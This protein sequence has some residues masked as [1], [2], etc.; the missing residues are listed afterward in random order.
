MIAQ[1][2]KSSNTLSIDD[3]VS[4]ALDVAKNAGADAA[5]AIAVAGQSDQVQIRLGKTEE[6]ERTE[7]SGIGLR[8]FI[9]RSSSIVS[10]NNLTTSAIK[11]LAERAV[12][13]ATAASEDPHTGLAEPDLFAPTAPDLDLADARQLGNYELIDR[14]RAA[15]DAAREVKGITNSLGANANASRS[16]IFLL[17]SKGFNASYETTSFSISCS[18][19]AGSGTNM[20]RDYDYTL[21]RHFDDLKPAESIG[22]NA[23]ER[24]IRMVGAERMR[25]G[26]VTVVYEPRTAASLLGHFTAAIN[27]QSIARKAS[28]LQDRMGENIFSNA[29]T[30]IDDPLRSQGLNS[31]PFDGEGLAGESRALVQN[32]KLNSWLL[33]LSSAH[34]LGLHS[35]GHASRG[36]STPP[37]PSPTNLTLEPGSDSPETLISNVKHGLFITGL[38]GMGVNGVTGDYSRGADG[39]AIENG[40]LTNPVSEVTIAGTLPEMFARMH[41]GNDLEICTGR[42]T[43]TLLIEGMMLAGS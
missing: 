24:S 30:I 16:K 37:S 34:Q 35:T 9:G 22:R 31:R 27:G 4:S 21:A 7:T 39:I 3:A 5:D 14:A 8:V 33:D 20:Q 43:P 19:V 28:F 26:P 23:A 10:T 38:I 18:V 25:T 13:I 42:D 11:S 15:E 2:S 6:L 36:L 29:I 41:P 17:T 32:G 12:A 1:K 40:R